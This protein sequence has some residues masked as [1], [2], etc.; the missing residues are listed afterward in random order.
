MLKS[1]TAYG[2]GVVASSLGRFVAEIQSVNRK[3]L[4]INLIIPKE[5]SRFDFNLRKII[6]SAISRGQVTVKVVAYFDEESPSVIMPN[7]PLVRQL[8]S[9]WEAIADELQIKKENALSLSLLASEPGILLYGEELINET[10]YSQVLEE[11]VGVALQEFIDMREREGATLQ[12]DIA[13][14]L[15]NLHSWIDRIQQRS[16]DATVKYRN[17]LKERIEEVLAGAIENEERILREVAIFADR[18]DITE[19]I[20]RFQSH[21]N[22]FDA[23][24]RSED[25]A[26]KTLEFLLQELNR[27]INTIG[28]KSADMDVSRTVVE[29]K[30]EL[31]R[32]R[33]QVQNVE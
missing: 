14:R 27:E 6:S 17:K 15:E 29:I 1:M 3:Y 25:G 8:K 23:L 33:E 9:A 30:S 12:R 32:I 18:I 13:A 10:Q 21:L 22:Q 31:E 5:F 20:T 7:L 4:E 24:L 26:G 16:P 28:A 11:V 2:R 19:E